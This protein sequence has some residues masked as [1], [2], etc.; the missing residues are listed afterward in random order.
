MPNET[1]F[2]ETGRSWDLGERIG[3]GGEGTV[4][5]L[6]NAPG[7][8]AKIYTRRPVSA[9]KGRKLAALRSLAQGLSGCAALPVS[10]LFSR[11]DREETV[12]VVLP[13]VQGWDIHEV[14]HPDARQS[15][16]PEAN[17][18]LLL[19]VARNTAFVFAKMHQHGIVIGDVNEQNIKVRADGTVCLIDCDS[20]QLCHGGEWF[21]CPVGALM[22]TPPELQNTALEAV[23]RTPNHDAFGLAQLI[24]LLLFG[25]RYPFAGKPV[26][27]VNLD[28]QEAIRRF[29]FAFDPDPPVRLLE[30]PPAA[31]P[32]AAFPPEI[33]TLFLR[34]FRSGSEMA[35][36]RPSAREWVDAL[37]NFESKLARCGSSPTHLF[38]NGVGQCP[39]CAILNRHGAD[40]FPAPVFTEAEMG[41]WNDLSQTEGCF[42]LETRDFA[43]IAEPALQKARESAQEWARREKSSGGWLSKV[44]I[45]IS[46]FHSHPQAQQLRRLADELVQVEERIGQ[47]KKRLMN[48]YQTHGNRLLELRVQ[49]EKERMKLSDIGRTRVELQKEFLESERY[50]FAEG[51]LSQFPVAEAVI[52]GLGEKRKKM[53]AMHGIFTA[54]DLSE[55]EL[56]QVPTLGKGL[57]AKLLEWRKRLEAAIPIGMHPQLQHRMGLFVNQTLRA[58][59]QQTRAR[60]HALGAEARKVKQQCHDEARM[61]EESYH[62]STLR[63]EELKERIKSLR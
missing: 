57:T 25:G 11:P 39:W 33:R 47:H 40:L 3:G 53:L 43:E 7:F 9:A 6:R 22:W 13:W 15:V 56:E 28:P 21:P 59:V 4:F 32:F 5:R 27:G 60:I 41:T 45:N 35:W 1:F 44:I 46:P 29:A 23:Q 50:K 38:W 31:P 12:G 62:A 36:A 26:P 52:R 24:F 30:P 48:L 61:L 63:A 34:A 55:P 49:I 18:G 2:D 10:L 58:R 17:L 42:D 37:G 8:C 14:Y 16:F 54:A 51:H 20:V 19:A